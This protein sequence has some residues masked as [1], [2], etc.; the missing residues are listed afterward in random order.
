M[1]RSSRSALWLSAAAIAVFQVVGSF[2]AA[3]NQ[4]DRKPIDALAV[5]LVLLGPA[6]LAFRDRWPLAAVA[7]SA[8]AADLFIAFGYPYGPVFISLVV[9][10]F[11]A[12]QR[13]LGRRVWTL[14]GAGFAG[15]VVA[16]LVDPSPQESELLHFILVAG[17]LAVVVT[18]S[19]VVRV[20]RDQA[21]AN[22]RR[23]ISEQRLG[24]AQ[25]LH[26]VLAHNISLINVQ[27]SVALHLLD[28]QP[29]Q[30]RPALATIKAASHE[31]LQELRTALDLLRHG[32]DAPRAPAPRLAELDRLIDGVRASGLDVRVEREGTAEALPASVELA[33]YRIVQEALTNVT[34]HAGARSATV[35]L[36][37]SDGVD[38]E[39]TDDGVGGSAPSGNGIA[40]MQERAAA[41]G[42][43]LEAGPA[44][45]RGFR[46]VAHLPAAPR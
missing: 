45:G 1:V 21:E 8:V 31:A 22:R 13:G 17:W 44:N 18:V 20:R 43:T 46:V 40:G 15:F 37:F 6:A 3:E 9:A 10:I 36:R 27:A 4:L 41:L 34:R 38:V 12:V 16:S 32:E 25:E 26:D 28:D 24:L 39:V 33:A 14:A 11:T 30:A 19:E 5:A 23:R 35:R 2:G 7:V 29:A 42:G